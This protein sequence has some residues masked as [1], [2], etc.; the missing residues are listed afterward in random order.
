MSDLASDGVGERT[1]RA[2]LREAAAVL[3]T[4]CYAVA[5]AWSLWNRAHAIE[6]FAVASLASA[7]F[8]VAS[9]TGRVVAGVLA[10]LLAGGIAVALPVLGD[11]TDAVAA[12]L[13]VALMSGKFV[14]LLKTLPFGVACLGLYLGLWSLAR[15]LP[16]ALHRASDHGLTWHDA[17]AAVLLALAGALYLLLVALLTRWAG[18]AWTTAVLHTVGYPWVLLMFL[19]MYFIPDKSPGTG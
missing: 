12:T 13:A 3:L 9:V 8:V 2:S 18:G 16:S 17:P 15:H 11:I 19:V 6:F 5:L 14:R 1:R 4:A 10:D 7:G